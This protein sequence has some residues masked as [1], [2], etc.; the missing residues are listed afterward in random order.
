MAGVQPGGM[1]RRN[2]LYRGEVQ[3]QAPTPRRKGHSSLYRWIEL[4]V[5]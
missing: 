3:E 2:P 4:R 5:G 1:C